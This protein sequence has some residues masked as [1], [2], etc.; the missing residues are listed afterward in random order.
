MLSKSTFLVVSELIL[1]F[2]TL[3]LAGAWI[4]YPDKNFEPYTLVCGV[5]LSAIEI[6]RRYPKNNPDQYSDSEVKDTSTL[7]RAACRIAELLSDNQRIFAAY[8]PNS[9]ISNS[10]P[11]RT[12]MT[13]W[14]KAKNEHI[15]PNNKEMAIIINRYLSMVPNSEK[16]VFE[17][18]LSHIYA[19]EKHCEDASIDYSDNIFPKA[20]PKTIEALCSRH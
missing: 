14:E 20:F 8:G 15:L 13:L 11:L 12:D 19:F 17:K 6:R 16:P 18:M 10:E 1:L 5:I 9:S 7:E 4:L 2:L 3:F